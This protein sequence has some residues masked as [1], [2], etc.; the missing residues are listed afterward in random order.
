MSTWTLVTMQAPFRWTRRFEVHPVGTTVASALGPRRLRPGLSVRAGE[1]PIEDLDVY[2]TAGATVSAVE[3]P[4]EAITGAIA[5]ELI[6]A[7]LTAADAVIVATAITVAATAGLV[8]VLRNALMPPRT[9]SSG[10]KAGRTSPTGHVNAIR[11]WERIPQVFGSIRM[12]PDI[13]ATP[14]FEVRGRRLIERVLFSFGYGKLEL[15][16]LRFGNK[17]I[18]GGTVGVAYTG[19][20]VP[21]GPFDDVKLEIRQ[22]TPTDEPITLFPGVHVTTAVNTELRPPDPDHPNQIRWAERRTAKDATRITVIVGFFAGLIRVSESGAAKTATVR[23][24]I[25]YRSVATPDAAWT[26][27]PL[28]KAESATRSAVFFDQSWSVDQGEYDVRLGRAT[29][30]ASGGV[31]DAATW[32]SIVAEAPGSLVNVPGLCLVAMEARVSDQFAGAIDNFNALA[33]LVTTYWNGSAWVEGTTSQCAAAYRRACQGP[34]V[35]RPVQDSK[36]NLPNLAAWAD[37]ADARGLEFNYVLRDDRTVRTLLEQIATAGRASFDIL[38]GKFGVVRDV[39]QTIPVQH[40][41]PRNTFNFSASRTYARLPDALKI[42]FFDEDNDFEEAERIVPRDGF[43]ESTAQLFE[44]LDLVGVTNEAQAWKLGRYHLA[45]A[46]ARQETVSL[47]TTLEHWELTRGDMVKVMH[48]VMQHGLAAGRVLSVAQNGGGDALSVTVDEDCPMEPAKSY[49]A[50][51]RKSDGVS[52]LADVD[53]VVGLNRTLTFTTPI[54]SADPQPEVGDL[55]LFGIS[56]QESAEYVV[57]A[58]RPRADKGADL[59]LVPSAP[60]IHSAE[61]GALPPWDPQITPPPP[62][63]HEARRPRVATVRT[64]VIPG[65]AG[66]QAGVARNGQIEIVLDPDSAVRP[67]RVPRR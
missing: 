56:G 25:Q 6:L 50:R 43:T 39:P 24:K 29:E 28:I 40:L 61:E 12:F 14:Y 44:R 27:I 67:R 37:D 4:R 55:V 18:L 49:A 65:R 51:F 35:E 26:D 16:D 34:Q 64:R 66:R 3:V 15:D 20:L 11:L 46:V 8:Y 33:S 31:S 54:D 22:G 47:S 45:V 38:D 19:V 48:D 23:I 1:T 9:D 5:A 41:T 60:A 62:A 7:G 36:L 57:A 13:A 10:S 53:T 2:P 21:D 42:R 59:A 52:V 63:L 17:P 30:V 58:I 32:H